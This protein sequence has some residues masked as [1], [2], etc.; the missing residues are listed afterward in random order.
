[1]RCQKPQGTVIRLLQGYPTSNWWKWG[2][3]CQHH[4]YYYFFYFLILRRFYPVSHPHP[5]LI[6]ISLPASGF[7]CTPVFLSASILTV[8]QGIFSAHV[9]LSSSALASLFLGRVISDDLHLL[10]FSCQDP[11]IA[12]PYWILHEWYSQSYAIWWLCREL[13]KPMAII[14]I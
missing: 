11:H 9:S 12:Q 7:S 3:A 14:W 1:M 6:T 10:F 4:H 2:E 8:I 5:H 13:P